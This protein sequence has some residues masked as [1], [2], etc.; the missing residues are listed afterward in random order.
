M[1]LPFEFEVNFDNLIPIVANGLEQGLMK[2]LEDYFPS[3]VEAGC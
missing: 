1:P 2:N 3:L